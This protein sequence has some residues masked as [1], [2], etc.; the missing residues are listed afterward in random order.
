MDEYWVSLIFKKFEKV[1]NMFSYL[2]DTL[3]KY[4]YDTYYV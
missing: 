4:L 2:M 3:F 1:Y